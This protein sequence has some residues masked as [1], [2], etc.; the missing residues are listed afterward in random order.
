MELTFKVT[1]LGRNAR[2]SYRPGNLRPRNRL[3]ILCFNKCKFQVSTTFP[4]DKL[5]VLL[6]FHIL[7]VSSRVCAGVPFVFPNVQKR[8]ESQGN[9]RF[10]FSFLLSS[11]LR[12]HFPLRRPGI[13][14]ET[15]QSL[16][17]LGLGVFLRLHTKLKRNTFRVVYRFQAKH[18]F[19]IESR[20]F[21]ESTATPVFLY[22][23]NCQTSLACGELGNLFLLASAFMIWFSSEWSGTHDGLEI[24][25]DVVKVVNFK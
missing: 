6:T 8:N 19:S 15:H 9:D 21:L 5:R 17:S 13:C 24:P 4:S 3:L 12:S 7:L 11:Q 23:S 16:Q 18:I 10:L 25:L 20:I 22:S 14:L 2:H 1:S